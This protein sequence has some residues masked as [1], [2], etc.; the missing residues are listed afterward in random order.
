MFRSAPYVSSE[1]VH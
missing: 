1:K